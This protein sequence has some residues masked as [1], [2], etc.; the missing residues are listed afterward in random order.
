MIEISPHGRIWTVKPHFQH[1]DE[2]GSIYQLENIREWVAALGRESETGGLKGFG[3]YFLPSAWRQENVIVEH[4]DAL[5]GLH[6]HDCWKLVSIPYG[7]VF[8]AVVDPRTAESWTFDISTLPGDDIFQVLVPPDFANGHLVRSR[9]AVFHY[10]W[11]KSYEV[12]A[13]A[14]YSYDSF[15]IDW[16]MPT[17][18]NYIMSKKDKAV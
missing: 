2:R 7:R 9:V 8:F 13:G 16:P 18:G 12:S 4:R 5:R 10:L 1:H 11:S 14:N 17:G 15:G 6:A 3:H